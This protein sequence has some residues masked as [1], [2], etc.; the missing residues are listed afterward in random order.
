MVRISVMELGLTCGLLF[1]VIVIPLMVS[2]YHAQMNRRL[3]D[4]EN[5]LKKKKE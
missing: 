3:K 1:L 5:R 2:R 4:I